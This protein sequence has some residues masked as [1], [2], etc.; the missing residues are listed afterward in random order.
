[1]MLVRSIVRTQYVPGCVMTKGALAIL[2][3][4]PALAPVAARLIATAAV[5]SVDKI[6]M[7]IRC[8]RLFLMG[9]VFEC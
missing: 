8:F 9:R 2:M 3:H 1:M 4:V 7:R 6:A 5:R